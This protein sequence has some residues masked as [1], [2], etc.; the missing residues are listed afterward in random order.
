VIARHADYLPWIWAELDVA[1]IERV[2]AHF[3]KGDVQR[4]VLPG[5]H[6]MNILMSGVLGGGGTSSLRNDPQG[7]GYA[8]ILLAETIEIDASL[9]KDQT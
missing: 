7:K 6:A 4:F 3:L 8:Q 1:R 2:F 5:S 9:L